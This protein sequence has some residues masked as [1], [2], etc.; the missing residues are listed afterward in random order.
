VN[1]TQ[2]NR[3]SDHASE[4][5]IPK[6]R[7]RRRKDSVIAL[8]ILGPML[9]WFLVAQAFPLF[10]SFILGF[11]QWIGFDAKPK[12]NGFHNFVV[13][14]KDKSYVEALFRSFWMGGGVLVL[15]TVAGLGAALLMNLPLFGK[16]IYRTLWYVPAVTSTIATTSILNIFLNPINGA[17][18]Q[19]LIRLG[20][21]PILWTQ[22]VFW[23]TVW[24]FI[25]S[26]WKGVGGS[27]LIWLA[28]LQS[29]DT[30]LYEAAEIDGAG[31]WDKFKNVTMPGI[32]P[33]ATYI[34]I[35]GFIQAVQIYDQ[36]YFITGGGPYG[37]TEVLASRIIN[38]G[39]F[40]FNLGMAGT[41][42]IILSVS[43]FAISAVYYKWS[44][45]KN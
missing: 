35:T 30:T 37:K 31:R 15:T 42:S 26:V 25:Y 17:A 13:F 6:K 43:V 22:S 10:F 29:I 21:E 20:M 32:R 14:F 16:G 44:Q 36:V 3:I 38:D 23:G 39:F 5:D 33:I 7:S 1:V 11:Y 9:L 34:F 45:S 4:I 40:N 2:Q 24:I 19:L 18:N 41:S 12:F 27:A 28:G 8:I